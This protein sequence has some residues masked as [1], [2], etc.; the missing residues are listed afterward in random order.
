MY[1]QLLKIIRKQLLSI[2]KIQ[3]LDPILKI[4]YQKL[5][6]FKAVEFFNNIDLDSASRYFKNLFLL[7]LT[8]HIMPYLNIG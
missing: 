5:I 2:E 8:K 3:P 6:Y 4:T 1:I 7:I